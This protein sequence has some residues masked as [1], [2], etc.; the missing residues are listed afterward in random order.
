MAL[1]MTRDSVLNLVELQLAAHEVAEEVAEEHR[2]ESLEDVLDMLDDPPAPAPAHLPVVFPKDCD[3]PKAALRSDDPSSSPS[4]VSVVPKKPDDVNMPLFSPPEQ[5]KKEPTSRR[6]VDYE[7]YYDFDPSLAAPIIH[8]GQ[9]PKGNI[10]ACMFPFLF[11]P[12]SQKEAYHQAEEPSA[13]ADKPSVLMTQEISEVSEEDALVLSAVVAVAAPEEAK[14]LPPATDEPKAVAAASPADPA[15]AGKEQSTTAREYGDDPLAPPE[16]KQEA[17][18]PTLLK[19]ILK[20]RSTTRSSSTVSLGAGTSSSSSKEEA[21]SSNQKR[22]ALFPVYEAPKAQHKNNADAKIR[23]VQF[24]PLAKVLTIES[25]KYWLPSEKA[26][27]WWQKSDYLDFK[28]T[29]RMVARAMLQS[30]SEVW[31]MTNPSWSNTK[32]A[33]A[34]QQTKK[35]KYEDNKWWHRF[36][37]SRRGLEHVASIDEGRQRQESV[38]HAVLAVV[39]EQNRKSDREHIRTVYARLSTWARE[40]AIAAGAS[41]AEAVKSNFRDD[42]RSREFYLLQHRGKSPSG[43]VPDFMKEPADGTVS[44]ATLDTF[45]ASQIRSRRDQ[46]QAAPRFQDVLTSRLDASIAKKAAGFGIGDEHANMSAVLTGMG[47][48]AP[49]NHQQST[50]PVAS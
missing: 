44:L 41:D 26:E 34:E 8:G 49:G 6:V 50:V 16:G 40:L 39:Q 33:G 22:R 10:F 11:R 29:A 25:K 42:R 46:A 28:K 13:S 27:I 31:L 30:G 36:G 20:I 43:H 37:H 4:P 12:T 17:T 24:S 9:R 3:S 2:S 18:S 48:L 5:R 47:G 1:C 15:L 19:G 21:A 38:K 7:E 32:G 35:E 45:T 14:A 23:R